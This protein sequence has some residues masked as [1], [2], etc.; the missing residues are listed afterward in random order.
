M[1]D[2]YK[3]KLSPTALRYMFNG[4]CNDGPGYSILNLA[5]GKLDCTIHLALDESQPA[6]APTTPPVAP[7]TS[8]ASPPIGL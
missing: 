5:T 1:K 4:H 8:Q 2:R 7:C 3:D 6:Q